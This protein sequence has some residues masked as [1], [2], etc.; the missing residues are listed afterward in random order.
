MGYKSAR[1][2]LPWKEGD[3][4][5]ED[6]IGRA[7]GGEVTSAIELFNLLL[8]ET[9]A[10]REYEELYNDAR[11]CAAVWKMSAK[12]HRLWMNRLWKQSDKDKHAAAHWR[13]ECRRLAEA[14]LD[15]DDFS[16]F[17]KA[18]RI[19]KELDK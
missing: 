5:P 8:K 4:K 6:I 1:G 10:K 15:P 7:R 9:R 17:E 16:Q 2:V 13:G 19:L 12:L 18:E 11:H 14:V 3:E